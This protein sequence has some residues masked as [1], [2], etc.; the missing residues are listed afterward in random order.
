MVSLPCLHLI[1]RLFPEA[2]RRLL[3]NFPVHAKAA[4]AAAVLGDSGLVHDYMRYTAGTRS[5]GELLRLAWSIRQYRPDLLVYM[6]PLRTP[7]AV[8][9]DKSFFQLAG[10]RRIVGLPEA[11]TEEYRLDPATG[12]YESEAARLARNIA[13]LGE[14]HPED[15][16]N[17]DLRLNAAERKAGAQSL[18]PLLGKPLLVCAPGC[19]MQSNDWEPE[20]WRELMSRLWK[21]YPEYGLAFAGA[22]EDFAYCE[23]VGSGWGGPKVNLAGKLSPRQSAGMFA[24]GTLFLGPDSGPKH[25]AA[26]MGVSCVCVFGARGLPGVWFPPGNRNEVIHHRP[27]CAGCGLETCIE[28]Q[29]K[30][31]RSVKVEEVELAVMRLLASARERAS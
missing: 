17:W 3:T 11:D 12:M 29:K 26:S 10:V 30:C 9:R 19:K 13:E 22:Q 28:M 23:T 2:E 16:R 27:E 21:R 18:G 8:K 6:M 25:L 20:N 5:P 14:A 4:P 15:L 24:H 31:I 1:E 7:E